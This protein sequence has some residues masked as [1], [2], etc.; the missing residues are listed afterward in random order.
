MDAAV[1]FTL[2]EPSGFEDPQMFG[3]RWQGNSERLGQ[4]RDG[5]L[6]LGEPRED[7]AAGG[8]RESPEGGIEGGDVAGGGI[9]NHMV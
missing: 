4:L 5:G 1:D 3:N 9:V 6:A 7:G 2:E 8:I